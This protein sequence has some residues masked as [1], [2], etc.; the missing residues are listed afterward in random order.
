MTAAT[1]NQ[2]TIFGI[3]IVLLGALGWVDYLTGYEL[4]FYLFYS[5]P[6][7]LAAWRIGRKA[8][9]IIALLASLTWWLADREAGDK[10]SS[11]FIAYWNT[12]MHFGTFIINAV[13][14]SQVKRVLDQRHHLADELAGARH[15]IDGLA[16]LLPACP[17]CHR[18]PAPENL[19]GQVSAFLETARAG[20]AEGV[21]CES[22]RSAPAATAAGGGEVERRSG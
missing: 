17:R 2:V 12:A 13:T 11:A 10:Y 16:A 18:R 1:R 3:C 7:G 14:V 9:L 21:L 22:C 8:G 4:G 5:M 15:E 6:V 19:R 20:A